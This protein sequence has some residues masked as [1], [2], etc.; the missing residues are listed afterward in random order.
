M[1]S[2]KRPYRQKLRA[3]A[4]AE[5]RQRIVEAA[6]E[7]HET[8][9]VAAT[10]MSDIAARAGVGKVTVYRHFADEEAVLGACSGTY[11]GRHPL[12]EPEAWLAV[13]DPV[14][15]LRLGLAE[16]Y[17]YHRETERMMLSVLPELRGTPLVEPYHAHWRRAAETLAAAWPEPA[18]TPELTGAIALA[19]SLDTWVLLVRTQGLSDAQ[20][21]GLMLRM[22]DRPAG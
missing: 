13:S 15:R 17:A 21:I 14:E 19:L 7:L 4:Q 22:V 9:G 8:Q 1:K 5:T 2:M 16:T 11:F 18:R 20:A 6:M 10:S 12:P 3:E